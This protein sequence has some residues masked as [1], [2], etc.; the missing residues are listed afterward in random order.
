ML[1]AFAWT[2]NCW[3][4]V[5]GRMVFHFRVHGV[6]EGMML[7]VSPLISVVGMVVASPCNSDAI[8]STRG[9]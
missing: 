8:N 3:E 5:Y 1:Q 2:L 7:Y 9:Y 4:V 6:G